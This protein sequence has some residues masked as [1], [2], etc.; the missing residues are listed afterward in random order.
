MRRVVSGFAICLLAC[1]P[2]PA[3]SL[4]Q[5]IIRLSDTP[6]PS[7]IHLNNAKAIG[8]DDAGTVHAVWQ[9]VLQPGPSEGYADQGQITYSRSTDGGHTFSTPLA[10]WTNTTPRQGAPRLAVA[11]DSV[12]VTWFENDGA[13]YRIYLVASSDRGQTWSS[14]LMLGN[15]SF[16]SIAAW[17]D[18]SSAP[19]VYVAWNDPQVPGGVS[20][21]FMAASSDGGKTF[22]APVSVSST[23]GHSSWTAAI[24]AWGQS[25]HVAWSDERNNTVNGVTSDCGLSPG[26]CNEEEYYRRSLDGGKTWG[27]EVRLTDDPVDQPKPSWCPSIAAD[28]DAVHVTYF[29]IRS[30][31]WQVYHRRSLDGGSTF[32]DEVSLTERLGG[33]PDGNWLRPSVAA[34]GSK[35]QVAFWRGEQPYA[36]VQAGTMTRVYSFG[37]ADNGDSWGAAEEISAGS[38]AYYPAVTLGPDGSIHWLWFD[39]PDGNDEIYY[40]RLGP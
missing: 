9:E 33:Q 32:G 27:P 5:P 36:G 19:S 18:G 16:P 22:A 2:T 34:R 1:G 21:I 30:G 14:R 13:I 37:S 7:Q 28:H 26:P 3:P 24:A 23:D 4:L 12:F 31:K 20:E 40:R 11:A 6:T 8:V 38:S 35:L 25:V 10:L 15:G 29:D 17:S 39:D